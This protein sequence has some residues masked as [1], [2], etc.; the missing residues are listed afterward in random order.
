MGGNVIPPQPGVAEK[1]CP[2]CAEMVKAEAMVCRFCGFDFRSLSMPGRNVQSTTQKT[3]GL[4]IASMVLG[5]VWVYWVGSIL[6]LVFGYMAKGQ[7]DQS[8]GRES[9]RG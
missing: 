6:A 9:G 4:A 7:I 5:I 2:A 3:N 1:K 8:G